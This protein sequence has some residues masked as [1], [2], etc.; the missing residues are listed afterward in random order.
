MAFNLASQS[1]SHG[2]RIGTLPNQQQEFPTIFVEHLIEFTHQQKTNAQIKPQTDRKEN[3]QGAQGI[4]ERE[5]KAHRTN[6]T[7]G[8]A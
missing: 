7:P 5:L 6:K 1:R 3:Y 2:I 8:S 4:P